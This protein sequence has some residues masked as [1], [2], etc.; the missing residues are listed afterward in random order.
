MKVVVLG[1]RGL[2]NLL[3]GV[4]KHCEELYPRLVKLGCEVTVFTRSPYVSSKQ[5][6][7]EYKGVRLEHLWSA[8]AKSLE[9]LSH[10]FLGVLRSRALSPDVVHMHGIGS[11]LLLPLAK[12]IGLRVVVTNHGPD[13][14]RAEWGFVAR[15]ALRI[16][17]AFGARLS[18]SMIAISPG[19]KELIKKKYGREAVFIPNGVG[20]L[21]L[22]EPGL[23]LKKWG[24]E[25]KGY[26]FAA[27]RFVKVKGLYDLIKAYSAIENPSFKLVIAGDADY[28]SNYSRLVK[29]MARNTKGVILTGFLSGVRL[30]EL[31]S[32][33]GLFV[34]PSY[35]EGL[36][37][38]LLEALSYKLPVLVSSIPQHRYF[39]LGDHRYFEA[40]N[41]AELSLGLVD[42]YSRGITEAEKKEYTSVLK[43]D[44][45]WDE[46][47]FKTLEA[48]KEAVRD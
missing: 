39:Q 22:I 38:A 43:A 48:Y 16:G 25:A 46:I 4:E 10:T 21:R 5:R 8:R 15:T 34:L 3:G 26:V 47:A 35:Y 6:V 37:I 41:I 32:N 36:P 40:G 9:L 23:E 45:N 42:S 2:P 12:L 17:E 18:N 14:E 29:E 30:G 13:Y 31:F 27:S 24:L 20:E 28:A 1:T 44:Y 7:K 33:A 11:G 19:I